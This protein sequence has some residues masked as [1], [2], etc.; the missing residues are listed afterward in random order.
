M[1]SQIGDADICC[2]LLW[3]NLY[4]HLY[5]FEHLPEIDTYSERNDLQNVHKRVQQLCDVSACISSIGL[6]LTAL[7]L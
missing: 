4:E 1:L 3:Q 6:T 7:W 2:I 5:E